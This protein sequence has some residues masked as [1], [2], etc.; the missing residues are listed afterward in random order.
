M[1]PSPSVWGP[2]LFQSYLLKTAVWMLALE[3]LS[4]AAWQDTVGPHHS[5]QQMYMPG[6]HSDGPEVHAVTHLCGTLDECRVA[7]G[8]KVPVHLPLF[9]ISAKLAHISMRPSPP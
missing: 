5:I 3:R 1:N 4:V 7:M 9:V 2:Q 6:L 8:L